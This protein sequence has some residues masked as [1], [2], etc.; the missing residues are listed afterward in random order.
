M[1]RKISRY[2][3]S[4]IYLIV[5][6]AIA[7]FLYQLG[8]KPWL[9]IL[10]H[11]STLVVIMVATGTGI[12]VQAAAFRASYPKNVAPVSVV[13]AFQIWSASAIIS[14]VT[15]LFAGIAT[16]TALLV[17]AGTPLSICIIASTRQVWMG[18]EYAAL[19][20]G[21]A[22]VFLDF[23]LATRL[24]IVGVLIWIALLVIRLLAAAKTN[25]NIVSSKKYI[26]SLRS[27][28]PLSAHGWFILQLLLMSVVYYS[29][30]N[31]VGAK[32]DLFQAV[33]LSSVTVFISLIVFV[34]NGLGMTDA[35]WVMVG[36]QTGLT[37]EA[38]VSLAILIRLGHLLGSV[39]IYLVLRIIRLCCLSFS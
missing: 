5:V 34:P 19:M 10:D 8:D 27:V 39:I 32:L 9:L 28:Y 4:S 31:G 12:L 14:V 29:G 11:I 13:D 3:R 7:I 37:L 21:V 35:L 20:G 25:V 30:F 26:S 33:A 16:R 36:M 1:N 24:S 15:P 23:F 2:I 38:S 18:L 17:R 22:M 6:I